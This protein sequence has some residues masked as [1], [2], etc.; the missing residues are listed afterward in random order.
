VLRV[1]DNLLRDNRGA[2]IGVINDVQNRTR[3]VIRNRKG[4]YCLGVECGVVVYDQLALA[5]SLPPSG[6]TN[7]SQSPAPVLT[8]AL[9]DAAILA[10]PPRL[11]KRY[12][13][14]TFSLLISYPH[15]GTSEAEC[16]EISD[17]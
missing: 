13:C 8:A 11:F 6:S 17:G 4:L 9:G 16:R 12:F 1:F 5:C 2:R 7:V 14:V 15:L 10:P 3:I